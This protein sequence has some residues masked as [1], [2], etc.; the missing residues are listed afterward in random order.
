MTT[1]GYIHS[2]SSF[3]D[4]YLKVIVIIYA[5]DMAIIAETST[6]ATVSFRRH[7]VATVT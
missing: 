1:L 4:N 2:H 7:I 3:D 5:D 6:R